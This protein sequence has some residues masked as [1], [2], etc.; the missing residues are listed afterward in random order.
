M[1][2]HF[3]TLVFVFGKVGGA[4]EVV[5][6]FLSTGAGASTIPGLVVEGGGRFAASGSTE[7]PGSYSNSGSSSTDPAPVSGS[8]TI[9]LGSSI[10]GDKRDG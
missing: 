1:L 4:G 8:S 6:T 9:P 7:M 10:K 3:C 5:E 2:S